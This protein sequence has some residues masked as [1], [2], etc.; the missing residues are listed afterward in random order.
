MIF[1]LWTPI[2]ILGCLASARALQRQ[3]GL[4]PLA[5]RISY[6]GFLKGASIFVASDFQR[7]HPGKILLAQSYTGKRHTSKV[8]I[9][10]YSSST[11]PRLLTIK[12]PKKPGKFVEFAGVALIPRIRR[13]FGV[14]LGFLMRRR[15]VVDELG[16]SASERQS[17]C[18]HRV[19]ACVSHYLSLQPLHNSA[20]SHY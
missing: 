20:P 12:K 6:L 18:M 10:R 7:F 17:I 11:I 8:S 9:F 13:F 5:P 19:T 1:T 2:P 14:C 15:G 4:A 3:L 16:A